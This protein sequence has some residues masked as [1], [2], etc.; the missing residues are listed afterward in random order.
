MKKAGLQELV[1]ARKIENTFAK[2]AEN[3]SWDMEDFCKK[4]LSSNIAWQIANKQALIGQS[5]LYIYNDAVSELKDSV[6][7]S[8]TPM[9][10]P[11]VEWFGYL[12]TYWILCYGIDPK[13]LS[14]YDIS[15]IL[16]SFDILHT[17]SI[18]HAIEDITENMQET[19]E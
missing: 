18:N 5:S 17:Y 14:K 11:A 1:L 15:K 19:A 6:N 16:H 10:K 12:I 3:Q 2:I 4:W 7:A 8:N 9:Y 13:E